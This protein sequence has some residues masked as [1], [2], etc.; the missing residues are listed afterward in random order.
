MDEYVAVDSADTQTIEQLWEEYFAGPFQWWDNRVN[1]R[2]PRSPDFK[3]KVTGKAL[4]IDGWSTP[5]WVKA[6]FKSVA[7]VR[8]QSHATF[9]TRYSEDIARGKR[10]PEGNNGRINTAPESARVSRQIVQGGGGSVHGQSTSTLTEAI[11][12]L[13]SRLQQGI[14]LDSY[15]YVGVLK[16]CLKHKDLMAAMQV[17]DCIIK[18]R[19]E[20]NIY[21]AN[22][23]L[24]AYIRCGR[25]LEARVVFDA[26]VKK[27]VFSWNIM[28]GGYAQQNHAED[29]MGLFNKMRQ[30]GVQPNEVT[31][32]SILKACASPSTLKW[33][34]EVHAC[35][36]R[37]GL[38]SDVRVGTALLKMYA[39]CGCIKEARHIFDNLNNRDVFSWNVMISAYAESGCGEEA[40]R[41]FLQMQR[42]GCAPNAITFIS[43]LNAC[44]SLGALE[45]VKEVHRHI[46][47][48]DLESDLRVGSALVHMYAKSGSIDDARLVFDRM[49][50]RNVITWSVMIGR[51]AQHGRGLEAYEL[52]LQMQR[53]GCVPNAVTCVSILNACAS[54]G[55][56][57][58]VKEV[59]RHILEAGLESDLRVGNALV[60]MY[61]KSGS[62]DDAR[63][64]FDRMEE[65]DV[66]TWNVMIGGLA[67]HG[68]GYE[69]LEVFRKMKAE[70]VKPDGYSFVAVLS[71]CSH[72]GLVDE[73]RRLFLAMSQDY[74]IEPTVL[75]Y[76]CM[77]DLVGRAGHLEEAR[78]FIGNMPVEPDKATWGALLGACRTYGNVELGELVAEEVLKLEPHDASTYVLLSNIYAGAGKW[79]MVSL[80][81]TM[82]HERGVR[83]EPGRC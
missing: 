1:K 19:M 28:I 34:K 81:R 75:H 27:D 35:I 38:E 56:L 4:W 13:K 21:V 69:A 18:S 59:H 53:D 65:R 66:L 44:A 71:A 8:L 63:L 6:K 73:G 30:E 55:A 79:D 64:V 80:V 83:K 31:Y 72:A 49:E 78:L 52:F 50:E 57:E 24:S 82:M 32:L 37:C 10:H 70:G 46:L 12:V 23:L 2:N 77:V 76:A 36:R 43:I 54:A 67:Q 40:Y 39:K 62:I 3:H 17:H 5:A 14:I 60:H 29:A 42:E 45:W 11:A 16:R 25:L 7:Q 41:L 61:S 48:A 26:L 58:W 74:G 22:N 33:G 51:L 47:D 20:Q 68:R 15:T 9:G